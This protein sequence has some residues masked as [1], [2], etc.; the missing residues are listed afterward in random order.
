MRADQVPGLLAG[1]QEAVGEQGLGP[2]VRMGS[3]DDGVR[4]QPVAGCGGPVEGPGQV[5]RDVGAA[6][7]RSVDQQGAADGGVTQVD[8]GA[9]N[10]DPVHRHG[11]GAQAGEPEA[12]VAAFA[13]VEHRNLLR[14]GEPDRVF[15]DH[16]GRR[17]EHGGPG[18]VAGPQP[19]GPHGGDP[20]GLRAQHHHRIPTQPQLPAQPCDLRGAAVGAVGED[21]QPLPQRRRPPPPQPDLQRHPLDRAITQGMRYLRDV[22]ERPRWERAGVR[23][24]QVVGVR[25]HPLDATHPRSLWPSTR[26]PRRLRTPRVSVAEA[27]RDGR[28]GGGAGG[29]AT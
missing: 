13:A 5:L 19:R 21:G 2:L 9:L 26:A 8:P 6:H 18:A 14:C 17:G 16:V 15:L 20:R 3:A 7:H 29:W 22:H 12:F 25:P 24:G 11:S 27:W 4:V 1:L 28:S 10:R 23:V